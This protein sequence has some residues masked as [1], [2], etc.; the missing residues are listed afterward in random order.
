MYE[1]I[2]RD[3]GCEP[4]DH[5]TKYAPA[6]QTFY[7]DN[8]DVCGNYWYYENDDF[9]IDIHDVYV[10]RE[11]IARTELLPEYRF[12]LMSFYM[13]SANGE[14]LDPYENITSNSMLLLDLART[15]VEYL[16]HGNFPYVAVGLRFKDTFIQNYVA[17]RLHIASEAIPTIFFETQD[18]VTAGLAKI[19]HEIMDCTMDTPTADIFFEAKA[20]EW[21]ALTV[22]AFL[23]AQMRPALNRPDDLA[24]QQVAHYINDHYA[25]DIRQDFLENL[26][27]M[28]STNLKTK[29]KEKY[30]MSITEYIQRKRINTAEHLLLT[31]ELAI[32]DIAQAVGY[33]SHSRFSELYKRYKA[34]R[35]SDVRTFQ[36]R[37]RTVN[38]C[39]ACDRHVDG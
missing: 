24:L 23:D 7:I 32:R 18:V 27:R 35:P 39:A 20:K 26:A 19:A 37:G 17:D 25:M 36:A 38:P 30:Q 4:C 21:V 12:R 2:V 33:S 28:S 3:F 16:L 11:Y 31:T 34:M 22:Q 15:P 13:I 6:G 14:W 10:K 8:E 1:Q 29:F 9:V 5:C